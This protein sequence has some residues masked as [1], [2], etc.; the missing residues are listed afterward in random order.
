M[1]RLHQKFWIVHD[2]NVAVIYMDDTTLSEILTT[3]LQ[4]TEFVD[5]LEFEVGDEH[6]GNN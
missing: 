4:I 1:T 6:L 5:R 2:S 3:L